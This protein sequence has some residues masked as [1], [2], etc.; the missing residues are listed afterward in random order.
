MQ[1][2]RR[3]ETEIVC[4]IQRCCEH[5]ATPQFARADRF[6]KVSNNQTR[7]HQHQTRL[8]ITLTI[9]PLLQISEPGMSNTSHQQRLSV[10]I[11][12]GT[13]HSLVATV[14][15]GEAIVLA[16]KD[17]QQLLPSVV[18]YAEDGRIE[19]GTVAMRHDDPLNTIIS[20]KRLMG[21]SIA[22]VAQ[23]QLA[24]RFQ[25]G[26]MIRIC[27]RQGNKTPV[28][29]SADILRNLKTLAETRLGG[30]I[31]GAVITVPAYFD[32]A[33]R[34]S[35]KDA[36]KLAG[37][38]VLRILNEP[39]AAAVAFGLETA[40]SG[41][42]VIYDLG[43]GTF[44]VSILRLEDGIF[45]VIATH[46]D[47]TLGGDDFDQ[48][49]VDW[50][51]ETIPTSCATNIRQLLALARQAKETLSVADTADINASLSDGTPINLQ[52]SRA[53]FL[54]MTAPLLERTLD[55]V[56]HAMHDAGLKPSEIQGVVLVGGATRMPQLRAVVAEYFG[57]EPI[58][59]FN[60]DQVVALG[61]AIQANVLAGNSA[62]GHLLLD[63]LP[64]SLGLE[65]LGGLSEKIIPRNSTLP[66]TC[67]QEFTTHKDG[68]TAMKIHV[69]QGERDQVVDCRSLGEFELRGIPPMVAGSARVKVSF[70]VDVDG[71]LTVKAR[72]ETQG[73]EAQI[74]IK[75]S[76]GL[77]EDEMRTMLNVAFANANVDKTTR[78][79]IEA[80]V[81]AEVILNATQ[82]ALASDAQ[83]INKVEQEHIRTAILELKNALA[84][85][86]LSHI[87]EAL[88]KLNATTDNFASLRMNAH[89]A[90]ALMGK[91]IAGLGE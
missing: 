6:A 27:T 44:D 14:L 33:Q 8:S 72:E 89:I 19:V 31:F 1:G 71:V 52:L 85:D 32:D 88:R 53:K 35:T 64:L 61:A 82:N 21:R 80:R 17:G 9:M 20:V 70:H 79:L 43:G 38:H 86:K 51:N 13:T 42:F 87:Q 7:I 62:T 49:I 57:Q 74:N 68:Q 54:A 2:A 58:T 26:P 45:E 36:A 76:Y 81:E 91:N 50:I 25:P 16:D 18:R 41:T 29:V 55:S 47:T 66:V 37:L 75:P 46:G 83:L 48:C 28:E 39:T 15:N 90:G 22:D 23:L 34:Q 4:G 78:L 67:T 10:G 65:T 59:S 5:R 12:L 60:P 63:V 77:S 3:A 84:S 30:E 24:Y 11:D 73:I 69:V 40:E 56:R